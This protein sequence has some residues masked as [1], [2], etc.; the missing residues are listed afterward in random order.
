M[1][2]P[3]SKEPSEAKLTSR[4]REWLGHLRACERSGETLKDYA[5]RAVLDGGVARCCRRTPHRTTASVSGL[6]FRFRMMRFPKYRLPRNPGPGSF[7]DPGAFSSFRY[8]HQIVHK[9]Y[10][11]AQV[12][13]EWVF[14]FMEA[15]P[16]NGSF[17]LAV[18]CL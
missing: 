18:G 14:R 9:V 7:E 8:L 12:H 4:Q 2:N 10:E 11:S 3:R 6:P 17:P 15:D 13:A 1:S 16:E 5:A